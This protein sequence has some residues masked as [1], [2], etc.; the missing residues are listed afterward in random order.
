MEATTSG[1]PGA[2][3]TVFG[4]PTGRPYVKTAAETFAGSLRNLRRVAVFNAFSAL[5]DFQ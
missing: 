3:R 2:L 5:R 1:G 4:R